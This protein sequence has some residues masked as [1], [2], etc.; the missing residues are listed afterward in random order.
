MRTILQSLA[1]VLL[2]KT[3]LSSDTVS[4]VEETSDYDVEE[5]AFERTMTKHYVDMQE[6]SVPN[7]GSTWDIVETR[8]LN[9]QW[10]AVVT[11]YN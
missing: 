2:K 11:K 3:P 5:L 10:F 9:G 4:G 7:D 6:F 1:S 8:E